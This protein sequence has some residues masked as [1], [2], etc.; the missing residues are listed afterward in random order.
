MSVMLV[1]G[2]E[3]ELDRGPDWLF[4]RLVPPANLA[5]APNLAQRL[6]EVMENQFTY[7]MLL[8]LDGVQILNSHLLGELLQLSKRVESRGGML[9]ICGLNGGNH[10]TL[11]V[12]RLN[13][14]FACYRDRGAAV[15]GQ[16]PVGG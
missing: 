8:E 16:I 10:D 14:L 4:V 15:M 12:S 3:M 13:T 11:R 9:R 2:W 7:R 1:D 5:V 6:W